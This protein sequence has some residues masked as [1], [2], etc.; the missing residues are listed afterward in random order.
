MPLPWIAAWKALALRV[1]ERL[2]RPRGPEPPAVHR[3]K[4]GPG[5]GGA[6]PPAPKGKP[7]APHR[8]GRRH[9]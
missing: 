2:A 7:A 1:A 3:A 9:G 4:G 6:A 5:A 8:S